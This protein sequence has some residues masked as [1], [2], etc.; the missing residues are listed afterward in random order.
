[1][2]SP[3]KKLIINLFRD[4]KQVFSQIP[5]Q[6]NLQN[7]YFM[8]GTITNVLTYTT[9]LIHLKITVVQKDGAR[10]VVK[11]IIKRSQQNSPVRSSNTKVTQVLIFAPSYILAV[12]IFQFH[13]YNTRA[14]K[15]TLVNVFLLS[16]A[17]TGDISLGKKMKKQPI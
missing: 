13:R 2:I 15:S 11:E 8:T 4:T 12:N 17:I 5:I 7:A 10:K 14:L 6:L 16:K 3:L 1:M 9:H